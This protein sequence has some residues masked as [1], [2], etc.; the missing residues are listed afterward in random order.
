MFF[1]LKHG[2]DTGINSLTTSFWYFRQEKRN[3]AIHCWS[4]QLAYCVNVLCLKYHSGC[5]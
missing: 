4:A 2:V 1:F 3:Y 5:G